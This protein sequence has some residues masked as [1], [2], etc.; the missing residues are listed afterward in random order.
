[1]FNNYEVHH[2]SLVIDFVE[3]DEELLRRFEKKLKALCKLLEVSCKV[4]PLVSL[5]DSRKQLL[6][7]LEYS[8]TPTYA[9]HTCTLFDSY[10]K[11]EGGFLIVQTIRHKIS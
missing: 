9:F 6:A 11:L 5:S 2:Y 4:K 7:V 3:Q 8:G 1:M 10:S